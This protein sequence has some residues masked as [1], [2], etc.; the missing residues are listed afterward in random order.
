MS[1][2]IYIHSKNTIAARKRRHHR[3]R[4][5]HIRRMLICGVILCTICGGIVAAERIA[6][7]DE[8]YVEEERKTEEKRTEEKKTEVKQQG[9]ITQVQKAPVESQE[10]EIE[11]LQ[12][13]PE[14][15][16]EML[17]KYPQTNDFVAG[18]SQRSKYQGRTIDL[19]EEFVKGE[20]PLLLQWDKRWGY[21]KYGSKMIGSAGCGPACMSMAYI[22][23]TEDT[24]MNPRKM[25][26]FAHKNGYNTKAGTSWDFFTDGASLLGLRGREMG[27]DEVKM[28]E[29]LDKGKVI[30][31]SM[32]PGDFTTTGH[33]IVIR[34]Y[35]RKGFFVNDPNSKENSE[36]QWDFDTL[37]YQIKCLWSIS[38]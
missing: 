23:L 21:D 26:E 14:E 31:C 33:F 5:Y 17:E 19:S 28:K 35:D 36:K 3:K 13:Y 27:L 34:G 20:V 16:Q 12:S 30:I 2:K 1:Q 7:S 15:L 6:F 24:Q 11:E 37:S 18:Y 4:M 22:Y 9:T 38:T 10:E 8:K 32:R 29:V 25:A